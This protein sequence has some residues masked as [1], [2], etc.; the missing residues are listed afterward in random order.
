MSGDTHPSSNPDFHSIRMVGYNVWNQSTDLN[1]SPPTKPTDLPLSI[2]SASIPRPWRR[3]CC[4]HPRENRW[5]L[6]SSRLNDNHC[7]GKRFAVNPWMYLSGLS[8]SLSPECCI[9][10]YQLVVNKY[11]TVF[12]FLNSYMQWNSTPFTDRIR[13]RSAIT[14]TLV[15][16]WYVWLTDILPHLDCLLKWRKLWSVRLYLLRISF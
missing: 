1:A 5:G 13:F 10:N 7:F 6:L 3:K 9:A 2:V 4:P 12:R 15:W 16:A 11:S 14:T 8:H